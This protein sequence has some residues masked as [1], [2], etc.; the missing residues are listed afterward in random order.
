MSLPLAAFSAILLQAAPTLEH[1]ASPSPNDLHR[2][3]HRAEFE[4]DE[5]GHVARRVR[6]WVSDSDG[7]QARRLYAPEGENAQEPR[8]SPTGDWIAFVG[9]AGYGVGEHS[10]QLI[11]PDGRDHQIVA[12]DTE[13]LIKSPSWSPD[14][15]YLAFEIR[16]R[17]AGWAHVDIVELASGERRRVTEGI[18]GLNQHPRMSPDG[19]HLLVSWRNPETGEGDLYLHDLEGEA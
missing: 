3:Y 5:A 11:R 12:T 8:W 13:G 9:G 4:T 6:L 14:G 15:R 7:T 2:V 1:H 10:L 19:R 16:N 18:S 17:D